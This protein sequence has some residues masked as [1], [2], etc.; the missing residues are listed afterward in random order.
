MA[1]EIKMPALA[2][3]NDEMTLVRWTKKVGDAVKTGDVLAEV[4]T[5]K[6]LVDVESTGDGIIGKLYV[7]DGAKVKVDALI[8]VL[9]KPGE[10]VPQG[11]GTAAAPVAQSQPAATAPTVATASVTPVALSAPMAATGGRVL[12]SPLARRLA[13]QAGLDIAALRGSGPN[14]RV[15]RHDVD[16]ARQSGVAASAAPVVSGAAFEDIPHSAM[17][18]TIAK[19]LAESKQQ[20]PHFYL[21]L[22]CEMDALLD[23]RKKL[24]EAVPTAKISVNDFIIKAVAHAMTQVPAVNASWTDA[25]IRRYRDVDIAVAVATPSGLITPIVRN[26]AAKSLGVISSEVKA[27]AERAKAG[28][29][30]P[31]EYQGG[32]FTISNLGMYGIREFSAIINPPQACI[33]AVGAAEQRPVVKNGSLA[34]ATV[35]SCTLSADHR[36]VDGAVGAEFMAA[37]KVAIQNPFALLF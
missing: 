14:G 4:E 6:A 1:I 29:L 8:A 3:S 2:P 17:R 28:R 20:V 27:L 32:T 11:A 7:N 24:N 18:R 35:M 25:A 31:Q 36:V 30:L 10:A 9:V 16:A 33:L 26:V 19:R 13:A 34:V 12:A 22:D 21:T 5:D 23:T 15:V 37:F